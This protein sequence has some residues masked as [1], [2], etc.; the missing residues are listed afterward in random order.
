ML[1]E[2]WGLCGARRLRFSLK[3]LCMGVFSPSFYSHISRSEYRMCFVRFVTV[4]SVQGVSRQK[5]S[6]PII[7]YSAGNLTSKYL[8]EQNF[9]LNDK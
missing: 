8:N 4:C 2:G 3:E 7:K 9:L 5:Y 6:Q 1:R